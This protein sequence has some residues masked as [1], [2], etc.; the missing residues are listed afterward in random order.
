MQVEK[1]FTWACSRQFVEIYDV[2]L[3]L[4]LLKIETKNK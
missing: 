2:A 1:I 3:F 4:L